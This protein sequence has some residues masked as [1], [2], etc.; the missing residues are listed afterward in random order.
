V[1]LGVLWTRP[2]H[3]PRV[4]VPDKHRQGLER[5]SAPLAAMYTAPEGKT[6]CESAYNAFKAEQDTSRASGI[7]SHVLKL[8]ERDLFVQKCEALPKEAQPCMVPKYRAGHVDECL[9]LK[10]PREVINAMV[11]MHSDGA[12]PEETR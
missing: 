2:A 12:D 10:P 6:P 3:P 5:A 8:A 7:K 11:E 4:F 1:T 9:K